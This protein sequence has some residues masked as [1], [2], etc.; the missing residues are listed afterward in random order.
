MRLIDGDA[1]LKIFEE[2]LRV[3]QGGDGTKE[4]WAY[5][6]WLRSL[7]AIKDAPTIDAVEV[8]RCKDCKNNP[9]TDVGWISCPMTGRDTRKANDYCSYGERKE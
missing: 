6:A 4:R 9:K 1:L 8:V 5:M 3:E 2:R 7:N